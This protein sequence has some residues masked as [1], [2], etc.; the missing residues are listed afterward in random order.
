MKG[1]MVEKIHAY[2]KAKELLVSSSHLPTTAM[3]AVVNTISGL[4]ASAPGA[5]SWVSPKFLQVSPQS[6]GQFAGVAIIAPADVPVPANCG[7]SIFKT[8]NPK[9]AFSLVVHEFFGDM[10]SVEYAR[11]PEDFSRLSIRVATSAK[12]APG[13]ILGANTSIGDNVCIGPNTVIANCVVGENSNLGANCTVGLPGFG[14][15]K[16]LKLGYVRFPHIGSVRIGSD[17]EIGSNTCIDRGALGD[18]LIGD[19]VKIDNLVHIAHNV[20][21]GKNSVIIANSMV[22]GS[23]TVEDDAWLAP[24]VSIRN[25]LTVGKNS[26]VGLGAVVVKNVPAGTTVV[27]NPAMALRA[28]EQQT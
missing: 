28:K 20:V 27:G 2:L 13:V 23:V 8:T 25:Q 21:L 7:F 10:T 19:G 4:T 6:L 17:V 16:D 14:Y 3:Q 22:A 11:G 24:S 1:V 26:V 15:E 9:L 5:L 18:T 12:L